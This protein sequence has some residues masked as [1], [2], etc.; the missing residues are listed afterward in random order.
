M[1]AELTGKKHCPICKESKILSDF[2]KDKRSNDGQDWRCRKCRSTTRK[3][4]LQHEISYNKRWR[5]EN[6]EYAKSFHK[7]YQLKKKF[8]LTR[9][10]LEQI[11]AAQNNGCAIC[12]KNRSSAK[13]DLCVDHCHI[14]GKIRGLLCDCCNRGMGLLGDS[15]EYLQSAAEYLKNSKK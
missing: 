8:G 5:V 10:E 14:T 11:R 7:T 1:Y 2:N 13:K 15:I 4:Y 6:A 9:E 3:K 12:G